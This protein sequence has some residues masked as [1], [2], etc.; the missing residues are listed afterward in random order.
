MSECAQ[1]RLDMLEHADEVA[2]YIAKRTTLTAKQAY[3][4]LMDYVNWMEKNYDPEKDEDED[5]EHD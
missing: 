3:N 1:D 4:I 2:G 5:E